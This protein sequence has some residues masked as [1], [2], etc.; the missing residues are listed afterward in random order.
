MPQ[1]QRLVVWM[2]GGEKVYFN[3]REQPKTTFEA[4]DLVITTTELIV[5]YPL[6][7][8]VRYTYELPTTGIETIDKNVVYISVQGDELTFQHLNP[9]TIIRVYA[10][11][12]TLIH[13]EK[14]GTDPVTIVSLAKPSSGVYIVKVGDESHK[15]MIR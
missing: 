3:L 4:P 7:Q 12:G 8:I 13:S 5:S 1:T 15:I 6:S 14:A 9:G 10:M 11:D 2:K